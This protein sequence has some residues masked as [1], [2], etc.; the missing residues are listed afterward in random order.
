MKKELTKFRREAKERDASSDDSGD[1]KRKNTREDDEADM[2]PSKL[3]KSKKTS[4]NT[5]KTTK[6]STKK[7]TVK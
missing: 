5:A 2:V 6:S 7:A 3:M 4:K 1:L